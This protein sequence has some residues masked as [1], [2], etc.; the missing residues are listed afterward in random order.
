VSW[1]CDRKGV[2]EGSGH[3]CGLL[4][5]N[6]L[7]SRPKPWVSSSCIREVLDPI[8][9]QCRIAHGAACVSAQTASNPD[10]GHTL[11]NNGTFYCFASQYGG[12]RKWP[13]RQ[14][15]V[16]PTSIRLSATAPRDVRIDFQHWFSAPSPQSESS[17]IFIPAWIL[18]TEICLGMADKLRTSPARS[19]IARRSVGI[20]SVQPP[21]LAVRNHQS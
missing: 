2:V 5:G 21:T 8:R 17:V 3:F 12:F 4:L 11:S 10:R 7:N 14:G 6:D 16:A 18:W 19:A 20:S 9:R 1:T 13:D 15:P